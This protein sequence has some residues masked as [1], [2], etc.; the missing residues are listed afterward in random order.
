MIRRIQHIGIAVR[1]LQEAIPFYRDV[2]GLP[3]VGTEEEPWALHQAYVL[4][5]KADFSRSVLEPCPPFLAVSE[6]PGVTWSDLGSPRRVQDVARRALRGVPW[7][8]GA[9]LKAS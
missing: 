4:M 9:D 1:S 3:F 8:L 6:M 7:W 2:L 5:P